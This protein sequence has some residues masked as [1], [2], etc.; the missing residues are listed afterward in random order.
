MTAFMKADLLKFSFSIGKMLFTDQLMDDYKGLY[1]CINSVSW[2][3][4]NSKINEVLQ[5]VGQTERPA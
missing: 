1:V 3:T 4:L 5:V 2:L